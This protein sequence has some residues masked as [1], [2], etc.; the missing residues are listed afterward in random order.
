MPWAPQQGALGA[1]SEAIGARV[2][3]LETVKLTSEGIPFTDARSE[4]GGREN[5]ACRERSRDG[6]CHVTAKAGSFDAL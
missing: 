4:S 6:W 5:D 1:R 2:L 3:A